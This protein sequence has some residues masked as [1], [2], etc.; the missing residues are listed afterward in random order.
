VLYKHDSYAGKLCPDCPKESECRTILDTI[1]IEYNIKL[2][3]DEKRLL[4]IQQSITVLNK[5]AAKQT[6]RYKRK[7]E[8]D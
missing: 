4:M 8:G 7:N 3:L 5:L 1:I 6:P 2:R